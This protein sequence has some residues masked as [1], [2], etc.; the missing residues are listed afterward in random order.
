MQPHISF[1]I[2]TEFFNF[3]NSECQKVFH[4]IT[5]Q[6]EKLINC[7]D[8]NQTLSQQCNK[9]FKELNSIFHQSFKKIRMGGKI[10][11][12]EFSSL[13]KRK[14]ELK[15]K[16]KLA[17]DNSN[18]EIIDEL[19]EIE[20][21]ISDQ[22]AVKNRKKVVENFGSLARNEGALNVNGMWALQ[23]K[24]FPKPIYPRKHIRDKIFL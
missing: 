20:A 11:E 18:Q 4:Q 24:I 13:M 9:W 2:T 8:N 19:L 14:N 23:K 5:N 6:S 7:F 17:D 1:F 22:V 3:R 12:T 16:A 15:Q 10:K 21:E